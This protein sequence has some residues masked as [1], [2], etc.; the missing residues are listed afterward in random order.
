MARA[1]SSLRT[2]ISRSAISKSSRSNS[3]AWVPGSSFMV[4]SL[5]HG[6]TIDA[7]A[8][9]STAEVHLDRCTQFGDGPCI[10]SAEQFDFWLGE[11]QVIQT[12]TGD[13]EKTMFLWSVVS[14]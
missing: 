8:A 14:L 13:Y 4:V 11:K 12:V 7:A 3:T 5:L 2:A 1:P 6:A 9:S 10:I